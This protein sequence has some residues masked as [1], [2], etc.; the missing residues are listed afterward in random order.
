[1]KKHLFCVLLLIGTVASSFGQGIIKNDLNGVTV[2]EKSDKV[3][4]KWYTSDIRKN[5]QLTFKDKRTIDYSISN[6][7]DR[8]YLKRK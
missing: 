7:N 2:V 1:M 4:G 6:A 5:L 8:L 3:V